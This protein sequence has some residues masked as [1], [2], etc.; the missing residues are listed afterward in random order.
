MFGPIRAVAIDDEPSHLLAITNGLSASGIACMGYWYD[1]TTHELSPAPPAGG[2]PDL[3]L[4]LMD[5]NLEESGGA[6]DPANLAGSVMSVLKRIISSD[7]GPYLLVFWTQVRGRV[8]EVR[9]LLYE[10]MEELPRPLEVLAI[11]KGPFIVADP[12]DRDFKAALQQFYGELHR[13]VGELRE[14]I[15]KV[16]SQNPHLSVLSHWESRAAKAAGRTVHE[17][18]AC[19]ARDANA[20][21]GT[22]DSIQKV[23]AEIAGSASGPKPASELPARALDSGMADI[24]IDQFGASVDQPEYV[25]IVRRSVGEVLEK[26]VK[27]RIQ[28][29]DGARMA[30]DLNTFFH[31]D[32]E[33]GQVKTWD[34]GVVI[35]AKPPMDK[36]VLGF[37]AQN[38]L[39]TEFLF[40][41][42]TF[43]QDMHA[44]IRALLEEFRPSAEVVLIEIGAD[45]DHAQNS[46]RT[47]RYL[48]GLEVPEKYF[49]LARFHSNNKLRNESLQLLGPWRI[50]DETRYLL[51]SCRR[52]WAWQ[53][54]EPPKATSIK[55]RLRASIVNKLLHHYSVWS[56]R[57]GIVEFRPP[58]I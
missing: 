46:D 50:G 22:S 51:V 48:V 45:C 6:P 49:K 30:A 14:A 58:T 1:R 40:P 52:F 25:E 3:R 24:L 43:P 17:I 32:S 56:S 47:R 33:I 35:P 42:E 8:E 27:S 10:R 53:K 57:P 20:P 11:A 13:N 19:A 2:L 12:K 44:E 41:F 4:V 5:L 37:A 34:R 21:A 23:L 26:A 54:G 28:F 9:D 18:Y 29:N 38:L 15:I 7:G 31:V 55:Y 16:V 36:N 39:T